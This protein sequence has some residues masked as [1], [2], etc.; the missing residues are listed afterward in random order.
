MGSL[1]RSSKSIN[2]LQSPQRTLQAQSVKGVKYTHNVFLV[3]LY[4]RVQD[5]VCWSRAFLF[6]ETVL[7]HQPRLV[8]S[9]L[10]V[11]ALLMGL[12]NSVAAVP[13]CEPASLR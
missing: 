13:R 4:K 1:T 12:A 6:H 3:L 5:T 11:N 7:L 9:S 8:S 10:N 2:A